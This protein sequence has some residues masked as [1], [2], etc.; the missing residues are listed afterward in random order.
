MDFSPQSK[1]QVYYLVVFKKHIY[2]NR[3]QKLF[4]N[5]VFRISLERTFHISSV[6]HFEGTGMTNYRTGKCAQCS[7]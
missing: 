7:F 5:A 2:Q 1:D 4:L 3:A 6:R